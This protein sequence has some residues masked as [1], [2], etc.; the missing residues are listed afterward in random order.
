M[1]HLCLGRCTNRQSFWL[2][3]GVSR[4][5]SRSHMEA[6]RQRQRHTYM[7][8]RIHRRI[9]AGHA[10]RVASLVR[11]RH[12][13]SLYLGLPQERLLA[14]RRLPVDRRAVVHRSVGFAALGMAIE[15]GD[16]SRGGRG[17]WGN[18]VVGENKA[19]G[20]LAGYNT[21][22]MAWRH[23]IEDAGEMFILCCCP[24][25]MDALCLI[26]V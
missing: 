15:A 1:K 6:G 24:R 13:P 2:T 5:H 8:S 7:G 10:T 20:L 22:Y 25:T 26:L 18:L 11:P 9:A 21:P 14:S 3:R 16:S 19:V 4:T 17:G 12:H 23:G